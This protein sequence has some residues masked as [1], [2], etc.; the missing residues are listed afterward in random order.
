MRRRE[1]INP[2]ATISDLLLIIGFVIILGNILSIVFFKVRLGVIVVAAHTH[3]HTHTDTHTHT[4]THT[5]VT[6]VGVCRFVSSKPV[7]NP[8][9][10]RQEQTNRSA[11]RQACSC[12]GRELIAVLQ[13]GGFVGWTAHD[14][15]DMIV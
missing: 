8:R 2:K 5:P 9:S 4:Q 6:A 12:S 13:L 7:P 11:R 14:L 1:K 3:I 10:A 15:N